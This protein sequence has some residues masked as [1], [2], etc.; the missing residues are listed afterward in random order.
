[1]AMKTTRS[2]EWRAIILVAALAV[3]RE[4]RWT[5]AGDKLVRELDRSTR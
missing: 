2:D 3:R 5:T 1:M 4:R